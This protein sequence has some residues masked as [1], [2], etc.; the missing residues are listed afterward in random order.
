MG[1]LSNFER[2]RIV[3]ARLAEASMI[4]TAALLGV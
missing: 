4:K 2:G 3:G 1:D